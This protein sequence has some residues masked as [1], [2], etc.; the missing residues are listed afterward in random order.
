MLLFI[1]SRD[2]VNCIPHH[3]M[4]GAYA[5]DLIAAMFSWNVKQFMWHFNWCLPLNCECRNPFG[6]TTERLCA[7]CRHTAR[8]QD[9]VQTLHFVSLMQPSFLSLSRVLWL[10]ISA[11]R[12]CSRSAGAQKHDDWLI[13]W[14]SCT[15]MASSALR[16]AKAGAPRALRRTTP[17]YSCPDATSW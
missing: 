13:A 3:S 16:G 1:N 15:E 6:Q 8:D 5:N 14:I 9:V 10:T 2:R 7:N 12:V 17:I 4:H 11:P